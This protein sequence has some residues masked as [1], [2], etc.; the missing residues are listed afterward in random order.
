MTKIK[1]FLLA[2]ICLVLTN[3]KTEGHDFPLDKRYWDTKDYD[4]AVR[5]LRFGYKDDDVLPTFDNPK[6]RIIVEKLTD[7]QNYKIVLDDEEL[8]IKHRNTVA[9]SFFNEWKDM[10][11]IYTATDRKDKYLY[12]KE[13]LAVW[14]FG[15]G[16]QLRY[17]KLGNDQ[18]SE[19]ADDPNSGR[20]KNSIN[21]NVNGL[22]DNYVIYLDE[23]NNEKAFTVE[24]QSKLAEGIDKYFTQ[25]IELYPDANYGGMEKKANLMLKKSQSDKIKLS[26]TKLTEL[27]NAKKSKE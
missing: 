24:G 15:L 27:I 14:Q 1:Y 18:I 26:L 23:I 9:T 13:M 22:I 2:F 19:N 6:N 5:E 3:C 8:G 10:H 25:L 4:N 20:V 11:Q 12:D 16:L 7:H 17:F 21:S